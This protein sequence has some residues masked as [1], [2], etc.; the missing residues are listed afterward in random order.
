M[1]LFSVVACAEPPTTR[2]Y[3]SSGLVFVRVVGDSNEIVR[4]RIADG[5]ERSVTLTPDRDERWPYWSEKANRLLFQVGRPGDRNTSDL[6]LWNPV[7]QR[8]SPLPPTPGREERWPGWSPDGRSIIYAFRGGVP[9]GGVA[10]AFWRER[11]IKLVVGST[12]NDF[13][14]RPNFSPDGRLV[15]AQRRIAGQT[16]SSNLWLL[17]AEAM[18]ARPLTTDLEWNDSKAW[19]SRDG[20]R[21]IYTRRAVGGSDYT[22]WG[23]PTAGGA[24][25]PVIAGAD[26]GH[27]ARP[28]PVRDEIAFVSDRYGSSDVFLADL[29]GS[30]Q[31]NLQ[32]T[33]DYNELAPRWSPDGEFVVVTRIAREVADF[34]SMNQRTL[35]QAHIVVLDRNGKQHFEAVGAMADWMPAW[36]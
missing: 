1:L 10:L 35:E 18:D 28:S 26:D 7:S 25:Y 8:E 20:T 14:M 32:H 27:S 2:A 17:S 34:G 15:V 3:L 36:P 6:V 13:F 11:R 31:R 4:V 19:F 24:P 23:I 30:A 5:E 9:G 29:D 12:S 33:P 16:G 22:V 21:I